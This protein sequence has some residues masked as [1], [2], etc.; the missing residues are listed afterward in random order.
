MFIAIIC[1]PQA[2]F[3]ARLTI[4]NESGTLVW[5]DITA[6]SN[7]EKTVLNNTRID[8]QGKLTV[9][10]G[11][12][13][14]YKICWHYLGNEKMWEYLIPSSRTMLTG[15]I[16]IWKNGWMGINFDERGASSS[17]VWKV[18]AN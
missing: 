18:K 7:G 2:V 14:F 10:S 16:V 11:V 9:N 13:P 3:A 8:G 4:Y 15:S 5:V 17:K 1:I 6:G 12:H